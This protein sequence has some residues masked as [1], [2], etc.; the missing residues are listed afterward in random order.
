M[1]SLLDTLDNN[2]PLTA[3][4]RNQVVETLHGMSHTLSAL[5]MIINRS[6]DASKNA[7]SSGH[8]YNPNNVPVDVEQ[9]MDSVMAFSKWQA[10]G[11]GIDVV[12]DPLPAD[13]PDEIM[14]DEKWLKDD[15]L[16]LAGNAVKYS[17]TNQGV[18]AS[19]RVAI[20]PSTT[21]EKDNLLTSPSLLFTFLDSGYPLS[22]ETLTNMFNYPVHMQR[23]QTGGM[24]LGLFCLSQHM[25]ALQVG[26]CSDISTKSNLRS[27]DI[28]STLV[29]CCSYTAYAF[30]SHIIL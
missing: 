9:I 19:I 20:I 10:E 8:G 1:E 16:C 15:L 12:M 6:V 21:E 11:T 4:K 29:F 13:L 27:S 17:R 26:R 25:Q 18:P 30:Y 24:G 22:D 5:T 14:M 3:A 23:M 2:K 7:S 28:F